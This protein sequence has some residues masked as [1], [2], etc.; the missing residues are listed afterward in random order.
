MEILMN[1]V[2]FEKNSS[3]KTTYIEVENTLEGISQKQ[4]VNITNSD[5]LKFFRLLGGTETSFRNYTSRGYLIT[6]LI[7]IS[8]DKKTKIV[9]KF[10]FE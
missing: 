7:S 5:T 2:T 3:T 1:K 8:P 10:K 6:K 4:Y 9:R